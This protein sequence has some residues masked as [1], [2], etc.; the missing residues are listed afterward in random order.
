[1]AESAYKKWTQ[2]KVPRGAG[3]MIWKLIGGKIEF[4]SN[5]ND[6]FLHHVDLEPHEELHLRNG[7]KVVV[8]HGCGTEFHVRL[9]RF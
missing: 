7:G 4:Y 5:E 3:G 2:Y 9:P 6:A 8:I 1:M